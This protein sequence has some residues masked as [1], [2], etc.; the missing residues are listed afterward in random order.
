MSGNIMVDEEEE[1]QRGG[2]IQAC[3]TN[4]RREDREFRMVCGY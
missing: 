4:N 2:S 3:M 1:W